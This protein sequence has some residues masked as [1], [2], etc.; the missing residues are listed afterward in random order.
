MHIEIVFTLSMPYGPTKCNVSNLLQFQKSV[1]A[2][3][4]VFEK[5]KNKVVRTLARFSKHSLLC[6]IISKPIAMK[7]NPSYSNADRHASTP[8]SMTE[9]ETAAKR[10][11]RRTEEK[12]ERDRLKAEREKLAKNSRKRIAPPPAV[13]AKPFATDEKGLADVAKPLAGDEKGLASVA[14]PLAG[15]EKGMASVAKPLADVAKPLASDEKGLQEA[16]PSL[17]RI[18]SALEWIVKYLKSNEKAY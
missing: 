17:D 10:A 18:A 1:V 8:L 13:F 2:T 7:S 12:A 4:N 9:N 3:L 11:R 14:K 15:D 5:K 6:Q 16:T